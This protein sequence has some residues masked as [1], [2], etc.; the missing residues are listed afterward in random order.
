MEEKKKEPHRFKKGHP[1]Y[2]GRQKGSIN[3]NTEVANIIIDKVLGEGAEGF[4]DLWNALKPKEQMEFIL[5]V[6]PFKKAMMS[7]IDGEGKQIPDIT[8]NF[9]AATN[10]K[11]LDNTINIE[12]EELDD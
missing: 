7:R 11:Q 8:I 5:K 4:D 2:G 10:Q 1:K 9:V 3:R 12:H 6:M